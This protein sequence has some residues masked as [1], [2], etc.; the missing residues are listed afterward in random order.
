VFLDVLRSSAEHDLIDQASDTTLLLGLKG[1]QI[2][3]HY[4]FYSA[5]ASPEEFR[6]VHQGTPLGSLPATS[7]PPIGHHLLLAGRRWKVTAIDQE[8]REIAV[9]P[10]HGRKPPRFEPSGGA[11]N[12]EVRKKMGEI[13]LG[14]TAYPYLNTQASHL[15][16]QARTLAVQAG[17]HH[18]SLLA[19]SPGRTLWFTWTGS[20]Q[21]RTL[22][23]MAARHR[24]QATDHEIAIE[25]RTSTSDL[26]AAMK[27]MLRELHNPTVLAGLHPYKQQRKY[28]WALTD[29]LLTWELA[30]ESVD[31]EGA[32]E[33]IQGTF[34]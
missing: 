24:L 8:Q 30:V 7:I 22:M 12:R 27:V 16:R 15:L 2:V 18:G 4:D 25:F 32:I 1:E 10:G 19:L 11:I 23:L 33:V 31:V 9:T 26:L 28:D 34:G 6:V 14:D 29:E 5:F 20:K 13:L 21:Q 17:L 3:S